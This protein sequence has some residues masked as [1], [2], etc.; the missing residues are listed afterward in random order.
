MTDL[1]QGAEHAAFAVAWHRHCNGADVRPAL[2][3]LP[4]AALLLT[5]PCELPE[6]GSRSGDLFADLLS[7]LVSIVVRW[8]GRVE[9]GAVVGVRDLADMRLRLDIIRELR[10]R[11][12][13]AMKGGAR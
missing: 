11:E 7:G 5:P 13:F 3:T 8:Q 4:L 9:R 10:R 12:C 1:D 6:M 2:R